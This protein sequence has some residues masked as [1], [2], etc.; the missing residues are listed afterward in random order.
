MHRLLG[1]DV[2]DDAQGVLQDVHWGA[3]L[4]GYFPTYTLGNLMAAQLWEA[5]RADLPDLDAQLEQRRLRAAARRGC[6]SNIHRHGRKFPPR[7]LLRRVT[8]REREVGPFLAYLR[9]KL[10]DAGLLSAELR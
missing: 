9:A 6:A 10:A 3:G 5:L 1:L 2:P 7:E 8:G 4:I